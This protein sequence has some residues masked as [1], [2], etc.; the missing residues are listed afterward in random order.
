MM[1]GPSPEVNGPRCSRKMMSK[2][3]LHM[4]EPTVYFTALS[5][6]GSSN[7]KLVFRVIGS[8]IGGLILDEPLGLSRKG[9]S[10]AL[11]CVRL[12]TRQIRQEPTRIG[13]AKSIPK[14]T[15]TDSF[16]IA[17]FA[18]FIYSSLSDLDTLFI[19]DRTA[20]LEM[21]IREHRASSRTSSLLRSL[22]DCVNQLVVR[23]R[24]L[25]LRLKKQCFRVKLLSHSHV[26]LGSE[27]GSTDKLLLQH[28]TGLGTRRQ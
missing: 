28:A 19:A 20:S 15:T 18:R 24:V 16:S 5:T 21:S 25:Q 3:Q 11:L 12:S 17:T 4:S 10:G 9:L 27:R 13:L 23:L 26:C 6:T 14:S 7:R 22:P 2:E 8:T 1:V